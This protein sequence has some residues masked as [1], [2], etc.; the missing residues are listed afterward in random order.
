VFEPSRASRAGSMSL[1]PDRSSE[2]LASTANWKTRSHCLRP[3]FYTKENPGR[4]LESFDL[5]LS[6]VR[7]GH[8]GAR[9]LVFRPRKEL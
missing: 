7:S 3:L 5:V 2:Y 8:A 1:F 4:W 6:E 9:A